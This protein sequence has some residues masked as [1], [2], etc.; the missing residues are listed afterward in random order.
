[1]GFEDGIALAAPCTQQQKKKEHHLCLVFLWDGALM[2]HA[3]GSARQHQNQPHLI[4][5][6]CTSNNFFVLQ[7][8]LLDECN[9]YQKASLLQLFS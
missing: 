2:V 6:A 9:E 5:V 4:L 1:M 7:E 3:P 8:S